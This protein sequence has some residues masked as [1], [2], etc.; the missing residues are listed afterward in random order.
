M[1]RCPDGS[2]A[3]TD[4]LPA[5]SRD[6]DKMF[7]RLMEVTATLQD[8]NLK[9]LFDLFWADPEFT[10]AFKTAPAAKG[11]H[12]AY[13]GGLLEHTL[14]MTLLAEAVAGH[15][16]GINRD[17][18]IAGA[19]LH[20]SGKIKEFEYA[21]KIDYSDAGRLVSHIVIAVEMLNEK[22]SRI[23]GFPSENALL[24]KHMIVSHHGSRD[25][26]SPEVPKTIE[27]VL[28]HYIDEIDSKVNGIR[29]FIASEDPGESWTSYH[30]L[31]ER[32]FYK[33]SSK[34]KAES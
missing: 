30:R 24:L 26:G 12:H 3:P 32:H 31:L 15:Y 29:E 4:F 5:T 27:A 9:K 21:S 1:A 6:V 23:D 34:L 13:L 20:D 11:M 10:E 33:G 2:V 22:I 17:L 19:V 7:S 14:S 8:P 16:S 28:L 18:L 25:F